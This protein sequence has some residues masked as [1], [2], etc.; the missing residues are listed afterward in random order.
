MTFHTQRLTFSVTPAGVAAG[1]PQL[2]ASQVV[3]I[4]PDGPVNGAIEQYMINGAKPNTA[5]QVVLHLFSGSCSGTFFVTIST[6]LL[7]T[8]S[9]G[10]ATGS[11]VFT[12]AS[13]AGFNGLSFGIF[14]TLV[15]GGIIA[16]DTVCIP[17]SVG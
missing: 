10:F 8:D 4:H 13:L 3:D 14:W 11:F 5:Y 1:N 12:A 2:L 6:V 16:Y 17:V 15:S 7:T 9:V